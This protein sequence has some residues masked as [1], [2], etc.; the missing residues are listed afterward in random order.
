VSRCNS[1]SDNGES[2]GKEG[3]EGH[4]YAGAQSGRDGQKYSE[5]KTPMKRG[6]DK[7]LLLYARHNSCAEEHATGMQSAEDKSA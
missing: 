4:H 2:K 7:A 1:K 5:K 6:R 3:F